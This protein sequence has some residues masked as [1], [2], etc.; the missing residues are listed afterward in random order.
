[1]LCALIAMLCAL[2]AAERATCVTSKC[3]DTAC[4]TL[5]TE[6]VTFESARKNCSESGGYLIT[7]RD[8]N[9]LQAVKSLLALAGKLLV[10]EKVWIGLK[11]SKGSCVLS[12]KGLRGFTWISPDF[13]TVSPVSSYSNWG[14][15]PR[16]T[17]T[18]ER[19]VSLSAKTEEL[20]WGDVSCNGHAL[21]MCVYYFRGMCKPLSL[22]GPGEI[23]YT[24][25][26]LKVPLK[27]DGILA[28]LPHGTLAEIN[29]TYDSDMNNYAM[30][31]PHSDSESNDRGAHFVWEKPGPFCASA[32]RSCKNRNGGCDQLCSGDVDTGVRC[33]CKKDYYLADNKVTCLLKDACSSSPCQHE[34]TSKPTGFA[35]TCRK[36][37]EL[38]EDKVHCKDVNECTQDI[39][40]G[41]ICRNKEGGYECECKKGFKYV[42]GMCKDIDEC[43]ESACAR[44]AKCLNSEGSF[45]C[46]CLSGFRTHGER[47]VDIDKCLDQPC[48]G[49]CS[50]TDGSYTCSCGP[51][52][53]LAENGISCVPDQKGGT[54]SHDS[55]ILNK[56]LDQTAV[57]TVTP[58]LNTETTTETH[59]S[60]R[61]DGSI[62]GSWVLVYALS[63]V[64][65]LLLL[66][67]LT[68]VIVVHRWNRSRKDAK[69]KNATTDSYCWVSS[70]YTSQL[71]T[72][73]NRIY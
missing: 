45:S 11:L 9:D 8:D 39:C 52:L 6:K 71:E 2:L 20:K 3:T 32:Q 23:H 14:M 5:H 63:S 24:V 64:I 54:T 42:D 1:M 10:E 4:F 46:Y 68:A 55:E 37:F 43:A 31:K 26:F 58:H 67:T 51:D 29:C 65:P 70:G 61:K 69:K 13:P 38:S 50:N 7:V 49:I 28:M 73:R 40:M 35:C 72:Q 33:E 34:C 15:E 30:C 18:E 25:P 53:H 66:I 44:H 60:V 16:S 47:C 59:Q 57:N 12:D 27:Q 48:E 17:C 56:L 21:Y 41:H 36:G 62:V 22:A 19:C